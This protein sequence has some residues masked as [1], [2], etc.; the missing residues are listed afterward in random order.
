LANLKWSGL[1]EHN[2]ASDVQEQQDRAILLVHRMS[3][4]CYE[5][6]E[7]LP[8]LQHQRLA[9]ELR[10]LKLAK[11]SSMTDLDREGK[12]ST[13]HPLFASDN[14]AQLSKMIKYINSA[15]A[16]DNSPSQ[17]SSPPAPASDQAPLL[18]KKLLL[19]REPEP[20]IFSKRSPREMAI[21]EQQ[22]VFVEWKQYDAK[23]AVGREGMEIFARI[24]NLAT[25]L[26]APKP[27]SFHALDCL[28]YFEDDNSDRYCFVYKLPPDAH[29]RKGPTSL[30]SYWA[31]KWR[32]SLSSRIQLAQELANC[33]LELH[34]AGWLHKSFCSENIVF[35]DKAEQ[36]S[37]TLQQPYLVGFEYARRG[38]PDEFSEEIAAY[39]LSV[40]FRSVFSYAD[41]LHL[42][43]LETL[44]PICIAI[45]AAILSQ[46]RASIDDSSTIV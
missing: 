1:R 44:L 11:I 45:R 28:G 33:L 2:E 5:L 36:T 13:A 10:L 21:Y 9:D 27:A 35:F 26:H 4:I 17:I 19:A 18:R 30:L 43:L 38:G 37:R 25:L 3:H 40:D 41:V 22:R 46:R 23:K 20:K 34:A 42:L 16:A 12:S 31:S 8:T 24:Q 32:P 6:Y 14:Q 39:V 15:Q 29:P 7:L